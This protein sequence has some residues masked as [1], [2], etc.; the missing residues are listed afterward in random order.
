[1]IGVTQQVRQWLR[2]GTPAGKIAVIYKEHKYGEELA[3]YFKQQQIPVFS[4]R[5]L[6]ILELPLAKKLSFC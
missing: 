4:R 2:Q 1:M 3:H 6:D 5:N